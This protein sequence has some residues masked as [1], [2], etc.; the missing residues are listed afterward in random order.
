MVVPPAPPLLTVNLVIHL[1]TVGAGRL[2]ERSVAQGEA[3]PSAETLVPTPTLKAQLP[4]GIKVPRG[5]QVQ[6]A[7]LE[8]E[9]R[10]RYV[11][12]APGKSSEVISCEKCVYVSTGPWSG[13]GA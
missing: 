13:S 6:Q 5:G 7:T 1:Q 12:R 3:G 8:G 11:I 9:N 10:R 4:T 2:P